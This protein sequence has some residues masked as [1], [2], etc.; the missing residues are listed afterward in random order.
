MHRQFNLKVLLYDDN[1]IDHDKN[2][3]IVQ[4]DKVIDDTE[5]S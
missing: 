2:A 4:A 5:Q 1:D 3:E